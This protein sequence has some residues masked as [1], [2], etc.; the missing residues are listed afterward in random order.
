MIILEHHYV[1][2][3]LAKILIWAPF[4]QLMCIFSFCINPSWSCLQLYVHTPTQVVF[5]LAA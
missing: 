5:S 4:S 1:T 2:V 3:L